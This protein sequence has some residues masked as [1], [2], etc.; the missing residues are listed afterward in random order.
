[1][2]LLTSDCSGDLT[3]L[4]PPIRCLCVDFVRV[5][6][7][8]Y[9]YDYDYIAPR[10]RLPADNV[11]T[12]GRTEYQS[13]FNRP[14]RGKNDFEQKLEWTPRAQTVPRTSRTYC[15]RYFIIAKI[16]CNVNVYVNLYSESV[17][18][19]I[20]P[21][22]IWMRHLNVTFRDPIASRIKY[23]TYRERNSGKASPKNT[24]LPLNISRKKSDR[25]SLDPRPSSLKHFI[26]SH[27]QVFQ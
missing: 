8:F 21:S 4:A 11:K 23:T 19:N 18:V 20:I 7:C 17:C 25:L 3:L 6:N 13:N 14:P 5:T 22:G 24:E 12:D 1:M 16:I 26:K 9:D 2:L 10:P 15:K 27:P